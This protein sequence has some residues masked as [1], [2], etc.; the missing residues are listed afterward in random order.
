MDRWKKA[1]EAKWRK[2]LEEMKASFIG[3]IS[4]MN[5]REEDHKKVLFRTKMIF[6]F[7]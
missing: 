3:E 4:S 7:Y 6:I 5:L 1:E 2:E